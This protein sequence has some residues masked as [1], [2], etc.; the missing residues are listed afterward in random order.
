MAKSKLNDN[1]AYISRFLDDSD[2][3]K[4]QEAHKTAS[5][6]G[7]LITQDKPYRI[8]LKLKSQFKQYLDDESWKARKSITEYLNDLIQADM[9][10]KK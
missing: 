4:T 8:N 2:T 9:D 3:D 7:A 5:T 6:V 10:S 1:K